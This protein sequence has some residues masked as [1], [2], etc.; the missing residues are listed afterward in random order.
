NS[1]TGKT[2][3]EKK[4]ISRADL[5]KLLRRQLKGKVDDQTRFHIA[6][7]EYF[8]TPLDDA[9]RIIKGSNIGRYEWTDEVFD[10]DD[11]AIV[12]KADFCRDAYRHRKRRAAHCFG[13]VW[14]MMPRAHALNWMVNDDLKLRFYDPMF[15]DI[16]VPGD[17]ARRIWMMLV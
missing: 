13:I 12:L 17:E 16:Y 15:D 9:R 8:L 3:P 7:M 14:G 5:E 6:D 1:G 4:Y 11:F 10:C 2:G